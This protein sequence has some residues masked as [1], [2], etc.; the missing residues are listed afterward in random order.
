M[1]DSSFTWHILLLIASIISEHFI[2]MDFDLIVLTKVMRYVAEL[3][4][5]II[6]FLNDFIF[7][8]DWLHFT[9]NR[10]ETK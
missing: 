1:R 7:F 10:R 8:T 5:I 6:Y 4:N 3:S 9:D 2:A